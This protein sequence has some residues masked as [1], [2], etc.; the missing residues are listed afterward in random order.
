MKDGEI[1]INSPNENNN[2][3][4]KINSKIELEPF[5]F[6]A[7][8]NI[9]DKDTDFLI[10][11]ILNI[12]LNTKEEYLGNINGNLTL[13][14]NNLKN[15]IVDNG[16]V[17]ISIKEK[18]IK[19]ESSLFE[20]KGIGKLNSDFR[21]YENKGDLIFASENI[22]EITNKKK[23]S[24]KFQLSSKSLKNINKVFF[25]LEK[26]IDNQEI[27]ISN[28]YFNKIDTKKF[29]EEFYIIENMQVLNGLIR[30]LLS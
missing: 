13:T 17:K 18:A 1:I 29:S 8:I 26:N 15:S 19:L 21:Y 10:D 9:K 20:I 24:R 14:V 16:K 12:I 7:T 5:F 22:F 30:K 11:N 27:S 23:F 4:I 6:D 2:Q 28:I 25:N 3:K